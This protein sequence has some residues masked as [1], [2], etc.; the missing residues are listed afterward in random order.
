M[1]NTFFKSVL[2][3][4]RLINLILLLS[5]FIRDR[6]SIAQKIDTSIDRVK[7]E[8][9]VNLPLIGSVKY[10]NAS[11]IESS[12]WIIGCEGLDRDITNYDQYKDYLNPLGI[13][14]L[15][16]QAGWAKTEKIK[17]VYDW[18]WLD[19]IINDA[20]SKGL[21]VWL[22][23]SYGNTLYP[24]GGGASLGAGIPKSKEAL[25]AYHKWVA[26]LVI[27]YKDKIS[28][29]EVW[30]EPNFG[31]NS[32]NTPELMAEFNI[33][34]AEIIKKNQPNAR[35]S[36]LAL[37]H[38]NYNF[39]DSF[40]KYISKK[41]KMKLFDNMTYHDYV[42]NPDSNNLTIFELKEL[43]KKYGPNVKLRQ[44]E[45]GAPSSSGAGRGALW[46][47]D[48]TELSQAKWDLRRMLGNLGNDVE[49]SIF[50]IIDL[51][52]TSG[53]I[54]KLNPKGLIKADE[55]KKVL[56]P[57]MAYYG[58]Q[59]LTS[60]FDNSL[61]RLNGLTQTYNIEGVGLNENRY[62]ISTDRGVSVYG[63]EHKITKKQVYT[64]WMNESIPFN[65]NDI[66]EIT[67]SFTNTNI[68]NPV[69]VDLLTGKVYEI[70]TKQWSKKESTFTF[71]NIPIYDSPILIT[72]KSLIKLIG[73]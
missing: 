71:K 20:T 32:E 63:Y 64:I 25:I 59:N 66:K 22:Q 8:V 9:K 51:A 34:T 56:G 46:D 48:W 16:M 14:V 5:L 58:I 17:G 70:P 47:Y 65:T 36:G 1:K 18:V 29:W 33:K 13:K 67:F 6:Y 61:Q 40:L 10:R 38:F 42:Y 39:A 43:L 49:C 26:A 21:K 54:N 3:Y 7:T 23:T 35:I 62:K 11:E 60:I 2:G 12:N 50:G 55:T 37:G 73:L 44:G 52:Y 69:Y 24:G 31:D 68:E 45:N 30:N 4:D 41:R 27:R 57:K 53:P 72:D 19:Y 28:D 15:R